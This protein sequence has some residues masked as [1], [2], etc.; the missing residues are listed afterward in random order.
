MSVRLQLH[1]GSICVGEIRDAF[2]SDTTWFGKF[3]PAIKR[4]DAEIEDRVGDFI[5]F[6]QKWNDRIVA[7][8][9]NPPDASEFEMFNDLI[10]SNPWSVV[11]HDGSSWRNL[12]APSFVN[13]PGRRPA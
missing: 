5:A 3:E 6:S 8:P 2:S 7:D 10:V 9:S 1:F 4:K 13:P 12:L 11:S